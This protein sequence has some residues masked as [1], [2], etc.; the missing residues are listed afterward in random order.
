MLTTSC[1]R[2]RRGSSAPRRKYACK[3]ARHAPFRPASSIHRSTPSIIGRL[4][5]GRSALTGVWLL[6]EASPSADVD[7]VGPSASVSGYRL[8][9]GPARTTG[10][11]SGAADGG[12]LVSGGMTRGRAHVADACV[13][14]QEGL[15]LQSVQSAGANC[16]RWHESSPI[17][18][19][20]GRARS[21]PGRSPGAESR[22]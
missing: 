12:P 9:P 7:A 8:S 11:M 10:R 15:L 20:A 22:P 16:T 2:D 19:V 1:T 13:W 6:V 14:Q 17:I 18:P 3:G 5:T 4:P 21:R